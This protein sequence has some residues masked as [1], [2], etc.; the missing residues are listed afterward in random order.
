MGDMAA[1]AQV[2]PGLVPRIKYEDVGRFIGQG[3]NI[4]LS[5]FFLTDAEAQAQ[6]EQAM[7]AQVAQEVATTAGNAAVTPQ[8]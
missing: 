1:M 7:Q 4:D 6:Q 2:P 8:G 3:R 5:Q